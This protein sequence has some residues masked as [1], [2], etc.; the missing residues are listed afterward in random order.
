MTL[1]EA[2]VFKSDER[3]VWIL[4]PPPVST[5][6]LT[7]EEAAVALMALVWIPPA[8]VEVAVEVEVSVP[9]VRLPM[10]EDETNSLTKATPVEVAE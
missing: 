1:P 2:S 6:P 10:V 3:S 7:V 5:R 8:K 9:T 4:R